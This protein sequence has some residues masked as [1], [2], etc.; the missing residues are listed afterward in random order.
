MA[1]YVCFV[2]ILECLK[3]TFGI[4]KTT[5]FIIMPLVALVLFSTALAE[6]KRP[7]IV[8]ILADNLGWGDVGIY[9]GGI[10]RGAPTPN[11]DNLALEGLRLLNFNVE[12]WCVPS[13]AALMTGRYPLRTIVSGKCTAY[14]KQYMQESEITI[15]ELLSDAGYETAIYGK[16]H[17][18]KEAGLFP[19]DQGFDEW[20]G[21]PDTSNN[22]EWDTKLQYDA[23]L[24]PMQRVVQAK[25][26]GK[27]K[28]IK[29][30]DISARRTI[31]A[32]STHKAVSF[33]EKHAKTGQPFFLYVPFTQVHSPTLP[34]PDFEGRTGN[35]NVADVLAELDF[36][37]GEILDTIDNLGI[38][39]D[40]IVIW[41]S[42][43]GPSQYYPHGATGY[44]R[45]HVPS[46][47]EGAIRVPFII[48]WPHKIMPGGVNNEIV[49]IVD[50]LPSL[51][52]AVGVQLP[53][54]RVF[55]GID[56]MN[57]FSGTQATSN[58]EGFPIGAYGKMY[59]YKWRNWKIHYAKQDAMIVVEQ[60][61]ELGIY[62]LLIDPK[63]EHPMGREVGWVERVIR[64][65]IKQL[66]DTLGFTFKIPV[67]L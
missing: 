19:T 18:G 61:V 52:S 58:R 29:A 21:I 65:E 11:I 40:T 42:D 14:C 46:A 8:I 67:F 53:K 27:L 20:R 12:P 10:L 2:K 17:L 39:D 38:A 59:A 63:E 43:N 49:H 31:D 36:R 54:D 60:D 37:T 1:K 56:Q 45:G 50:L 41:T 62:N 15:A 5:S 28:D 47:L 66:E 33:I 7:N 64:N 23:S 30:Y 6:E 34:H 26:G 24:A 44:W 22:A 48:R 51:A 32:E 55:D 3:Q 13:R 25:K 35:G 4:K 9:G 57:F 16:W